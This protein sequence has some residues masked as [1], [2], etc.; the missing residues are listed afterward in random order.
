MPALPAALPLLIQPLRLHARER[1][2]AAGVENYIR[3]V[4]WLLADVLQSPVAGFLSGQNTALSPAQVAKAWDFIQ[5]RAAREP[6][7]YILGSQEFKGCD[8]DVTRDVLIPRPE[9][10]L[11]VDEVLHLLT[12]RP[13][14]IVVDVG[15]GSGCIAVA[16]G[17]IRADARI[18]A[19]DI[20][21]CAL[22]VAK[23]NV[24]RY[25]LIPQVRFI[26]G[27]MVEGFAVRPGGTFDAIVSNPPYIPDEDY[28]LLQ[29]EVARYEPRVALAGG[30]DG[31]HFYRQLLGHA[32]SLLKTGGHMVLELGLGQADKVRDLVARKTGLVM[33]HS[34][35]DD[36][37]IERVMVLKKAA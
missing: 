9:T 23:A 37:G 33:T 24:A 25:G 22:A 10:E 34:T 28:A 26:Q 29:P 4:D 15:T 7:Q 2:K 17:K 18:Y 31:L 11:L 3:E 1:L 27:N 35:R 14:P 13:R 20:S 8:I 6:L 12:G 30:P 5:R 32:A 36:A 19:V 21:G 16:I